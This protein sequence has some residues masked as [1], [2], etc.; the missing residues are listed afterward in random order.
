[1]AS[2]QPRVAAKQ[3]TESKRKFSM[4]LRALVATIFGPW[5]FYSS[6]ESKMKV[7]KISDRRADI[8]QKMRTV[9]RKGTEI[10]QLQ[11]E[12]EALKIEIEA[13]ILSYSKS[14]CLKFASAFHNRLPRE[15]R[16][17]VYE[18]FISN[19]RSDLK[20][21]S[22]DP[23][24]Y[25]HSKLLHIKDSNHYIFIA[26][27]VGLTVA[28]EAAAYLYSQTQFRLLYA[29]QI[30]HFL[31]I[32]TNIF[33]Y[34]LDPKTL[35][36]SLE[37]VVHYDKVAHWYKKS[38]SMLGANKKPDA[39]GIREIRNTQ[40]RSLNTLLGI[41]NI[42]GFRLIVLVNADRFELQSR[43]RALD[44][45]KDIGPT[46][47]RLKEKGM[48]IEVAQSYKFSF[49]IDNCFGGW[50]D[51]SLEQWETSIEERREMFAPTKNRMNVD[52]VLEDSVLSRAF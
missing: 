52:K 7:A 46:L 5:K 12:T 15:L 14:D 27:W 9:D 23:I 1:M 3:P 42:E 29:H 36:R 45:L 38:N 8:L 28:T 34:D 33:G 40:I 10:K 22:Q 21:R 32:P 51:G 39:D 31:K 13:N 2:T 49:D 44:V 35:I 25:Q 48:R 24:Y 41:K 37:L 18:H 4:Q 16:Y 47:W 20:I 50:L 26:D 30:D 6:I 43:V 19:L 11:T 17:M